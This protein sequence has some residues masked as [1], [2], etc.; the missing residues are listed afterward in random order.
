MGLSRSQ[1]SRQQD[2][3]SDSKDVDPCLQAIQLRTRSTMA[4]VTDGVK[5]TSPSCHTKKNKKQ[6]LGLW[7][8]SYLFDDEPLAG[9]CQ[10][11]GRSAT[12]SSGS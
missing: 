11:Q 5:N 2:G 10:H 4:R 9:R 12:T 1:A 3:S 8:G 6:D 7:T